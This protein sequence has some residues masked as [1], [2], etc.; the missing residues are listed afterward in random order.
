MKDKS[1]N[2]RR[3]GKYEVN[4]AY[5][6]YADCAFPNYETCHPCCENAADSVLC[7]LTNDECPWPNCK[8]VLRKFTS[9]NSIAFPGVEKDS[10]NQAVI[11]AFNTYMTQFTCLHPGI[12]IR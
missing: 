4:Q 7:T 3:R 1:D 12:L 11:I 9:C 8:C 2:S 10:L 6:S 5:K